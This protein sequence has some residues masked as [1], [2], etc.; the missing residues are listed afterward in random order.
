MSNGLDIVNNY[1]NSFT[2]KTPIEF[3]L[4]ETGKTTLKMYN[5]LGKEVAVLSDDLATGGQR[6]TL[7]FDGSQLREVSVSTTSAVVMM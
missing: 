2:E 4:E 6:Y 5:I 1:P 3:V 7:N